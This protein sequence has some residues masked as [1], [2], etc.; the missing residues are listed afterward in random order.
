MS[1]V[2][3]EISRQSGQTIRYQNLPE[4]EYRAILL[5][6]GLPEV[7]AAGLA[8][9]DV[10]ASQGALFADSRQLNRLIGRPTTPLAD[11]VMAALRHR[12]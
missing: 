5:A 10:G 1:D 12:S 6:A 7:L 2:A 9:W 8:S 3:A 4:A 11:S